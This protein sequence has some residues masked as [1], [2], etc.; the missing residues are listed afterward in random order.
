MAQARIWPAQPSA[1]FPYECLGPSDA[2][3]HD[4]AQLQPHVSTRL[5]AAMQPP[6]EDQLPAVR[7]RLRWLPNPLGVLI[8][9]SLLSVNIAHLEGQRRARLQATQHVL[10]D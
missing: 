5:W 8:T 6:T 4:L 1:D 9:S 10:A 7:E 2:A 3:Q